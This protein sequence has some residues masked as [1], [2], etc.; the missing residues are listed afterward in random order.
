MLNSELQTLQ[1]YVADCASRNLIQWWFETRGTPARDGL[2]RA[3][4]DSRTKGLR[5][6]TSPA[7]RRAVWQCALQHETL[8]ALIAR[9]AGLISDCPA[10]EPGDRIRLRNSL[11]ILDASGKIIRVHR[12]GETWRVVGRDAARS[13]WLEQPDGCRQMWDDDREILAQFEKLAA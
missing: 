5:P 4:F 2:N 10:L 8:H 6:L 3:L 11:P 12:G 7:V 9:S 1:A 13:V